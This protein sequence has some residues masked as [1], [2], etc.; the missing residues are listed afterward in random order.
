MAELGA[1]AS[2]V[3]LADVA[4]RMSGEICKF[5]DAYKHADRDAKSL[6]NGNMNAD[7]N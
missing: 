4:L 7:V 6:R 5:L 3:Q 1:V 2:V